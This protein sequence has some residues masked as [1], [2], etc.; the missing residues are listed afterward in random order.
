M[1]Y[2]GFV[3]L[4][5]HSDY[6]LLDG[7]GRTVDYINRALD[8]RMPAVAITDHGCMF[9]AVEFYSQALKMGIKPLVGCEFY[10]T[11]GSRFEKKANLEN[12]NHLVLIAENTEGYHN[13]MKLSSKAH[14]EG[15]YYRPRIDFELLEKYGKNLVAL[16]AC[17]KGIVNEDLGKGDLDQARRMADRLIEIFGKQ[18]VF[19]EIQRHGLEEE[20]RIIPRAIELSKRLGIGLVATNDCHYVNRDDAK[21]HDI[22]L[23]IQTGTDLDDPNRLRF[24][25]DQFY[26]KTPD[27]MK[28]LF[29]AVPEAIKNTVSIA[30]RCTLDLDLGRIHLPKYQIPEGFRDEDHYLTHLAYEGL[31]RRYPQDNQE[32]LRRLE[33]EIRVIQEMKYSSYFLIVKDIVDAARKKGIPVGPGRG[34]AAGS[35]V[36]YCLGITN[37]DPL[38]FKLIFERFLN[39]ERVSMPDI[40]IDFCDRRRQEVIDYVVEKYGKDSVAQIITFGTLGAKAAIRDVGR[41]LRIPMQEVDRIAKMIPA[42]PGITLASA[43][44]RVKELKEVSESPKYKDLISMARK[45]EGLARHASTHAAGVLIAP[46]DITNYVPLYR[47]AKGEVVTQYDM[48]SIEAIGLLKMD[49][50]GLTTLTIIHDTLD[51]INRRY[52]IKL[53]IDEIPLDDP[54]VYRMLAAGQTVGVFQLESSGMRDLLRRLSPERFQDIIAINALYRPG[55]LGSEMVEQFIRRKRGTDPIQYDHPLLEPILKDTYGVMLYQEQIIEIA[56]AVAGFT[57]GQAD[58][59]RRAIGKKKDEIMEMQCR[60]F[61]KGAVANGISEELAEEIFS[62]MAFFSRYGFNKSHSTA[63]ALISYQTAYLKCKYPTE[64]M[65]ACLSNEINNIDRICVLL[66]EC[67]RM[68][69]DVLPPDVNESEVDFLPG[70]RSI[71]FGLGAIKNVGRAAIESIVSARKS[72]GKFKSIFDLCERVDLRAVNK[73]VI[74]S[75]IYSGALDSLGG[76]RAQLHSAIE[77]A[78]AVGQRARE[79]NHSG[80]MSLLSA[81]SDTG[82]S[83]IE[84]KLPDVEEWSLM[85]KLAHEREV[86]GFYCSDH[87]LSRFKMEIDCFTSARI[88]EVR[89]MKDRERVTIAGIVGRKRVFLGKDAKKMAFV[90]LEDTTG[91]I[92]L[93]FFDE[94]YACAESKLNPGTMII[95]HGIVSAKNDE[96]PRIRVHD[97]IEIEKALEQ[98]CEGIEVEIDRSELTAEGSELI[99]RLLKMN[100]GK[101]PVIMRIRRK[102]LGDIEMEVGDISVRPSRELIA[103]LN[104]IKGVL[105][106]KLVKKKWMARKGNH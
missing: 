27:E 41:V 86:L 93:I 9:G 85:E 26:F 19:L 88:A 5:V 99:N 21:A 59:I 13:L 43:I 61:V 16:T 63:Y 103:R 50:L 104:G 81:L 35:I 8:L 64:F 45:L 11:S 92:E 94:Q 75:L 24:A 95:V 65:A 69:I 14:T 25:N 30:E 47:G 102:D 68:G 82:D 97:W 2:S 96:Q 74:E 18:N 101:V 32:A 33:Y 100:P 73:R 38:K 37:V 46:G 22:L 48:N 90:S 79:E 34:S 49:F 4:H 1:K 39:P 31:K 10:V 83:E 72:G 15:F 40:D 84:R 105:G 76:H 66:E 12:L 52:G 42:E 106:V 78:L 23:C 29:E 54:E 58:T 20:E 3:H 62:K 56:S 51:L 71:R 87:P 77:L 53:E 36:A 17:L 44:E 98:L 89:E 67:R 80:Q 91:Q 57:R 60:N 55:P 28:S 70:D 7:A 6:S